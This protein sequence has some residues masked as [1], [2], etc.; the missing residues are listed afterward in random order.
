MERKYLGKEE[1][2]K[3]YI[4]VCHVFINSKPHTT[5]SLVIKKWSPGISK[6]EE[7]AKAFYEDFLLISGIVHF[8]LT[9]N[10]I[11]RLFTYK[12]YSSD[13]DYCLLWT[14][15]NNHLFI[16][17]SIKLGNNNNLKRV[18]VFSFV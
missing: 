7:S 4:R 11:I 13:S 6:E 12:L 9:D 2:G 8:L 15:W 1:T 14:N 5:R 17:N 3:F 10:V 18:G 16:S